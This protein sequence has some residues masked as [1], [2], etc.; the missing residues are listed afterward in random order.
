MFSNPA[1]AAVDQHEP[2]L[3]E[4]TMELFFEDAFRDELEQG[5]SYETNCLG[6]KPPAR[7]TKW[8]YDAARSEAR[9]EKNPEMQR[10]W[11]QAEVD[12]IDSL[13]G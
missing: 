7:M 11:Q 1:E 2:T 9:R 8:F 5:L 4:R 3:D 13:I 10:A 6:M 12:Y